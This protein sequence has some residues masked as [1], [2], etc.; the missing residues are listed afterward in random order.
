MSVTDKT[1][2]QID[3][4]RCQTDW[5]T[6]LKIRRGIWQYLIKPLY[7]LLPC[8]Q[9]RICVLRLCGARIGKNCN[10]QRGVDILMPWNL[11][12][13]DYVALAHHTRVLNF[14]PVR[15]DSM[16]VISQYVHLCTGTHD[17]TDPYFKLLFKPIRIGAES[18]V[19]SGAFIGP[20]VT[21]GRGCVIGANAVVTKDMPE[22]KVCAG[23][24]CKPLKTRVVRTQA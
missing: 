4:S 2:F 13:G 21:L 18:W 14:S 3:L 20:G 7:Y 15:I 22:W 5:D 11:E 24:P 17:Y 23:H 10:I 16:T 9:L 12:L 6:K 8:R 19:A 1:Q